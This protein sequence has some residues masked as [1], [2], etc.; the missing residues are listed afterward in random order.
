MGS[1]TDSHCHRA[2]RI[3]TDIARRLPMSEQ[4]IE[5]P[6]PT[7]AGNY[8]F[9]DGSRIVHASDLPG[10]WNAYQ[11]D[12]T[13]LAKAE[14]VLSYF[15][16][17]KEAAKALANGGRGIAEKPE[18]AP[19]PSH[20]RYIVWSGF[21]DWKVCGTL[22][23]ALE[24]K[25]SHGGTIYEPLGMSTAERVCLEEAMREALEKIIR[26]DVSTRIGIAG[27]MAEIARDALEVM[28]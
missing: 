5:L 9:P 26:L 3:L 19:S 14:G 10:W 24:W 4:P 15:S 20:P 12:G 7:L 11:A 27:R 25:G 28:S 6:A 23:A 18:P 8:F 22:A 16:T 21:R 13:P 17:A 1:E 2:R